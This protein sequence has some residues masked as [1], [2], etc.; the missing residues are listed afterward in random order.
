[1]K[2]DPQRRHWADIRLECIFPD[3]V[4]AGEEFDVEVS[5]TDVKNENASLPWI[6]FSFLAAHTRIHTFVTKRRRAGR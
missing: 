5:L 2:D 4:E 1:M 3:T 6:E